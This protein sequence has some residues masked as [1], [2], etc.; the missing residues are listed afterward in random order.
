MKAELKKGDWQPS[1]GDRGSHD[2]IYDADGDLIADV[3]FDDAGNIRLLTSDDI[4]KAVN[5]L[6]RVTSAL[7]DLLESNDPDISK[8]QEVLALLE[9]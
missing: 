2:S 7:K 9:R 5:N 8:A 1:T 4:C 6:E 3:G